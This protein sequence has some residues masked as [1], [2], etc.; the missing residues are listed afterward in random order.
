MDAAYNACIIRN[1]RFETWVNASRSLLQSN[2]FEDK[3][4]SV[5]DIRQL[6]SSLIHT[7]SRSKVPI[8]NG[9]Y[10]GFG[11]DNLRRRQAKCHNP[12]LRHCSQAK[13]SF[14]VN[15]QHWSCLSLQLIPS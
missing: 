9:I 3:D 5:L 2:H 1:E 12:V 4:A 14:S 13:V 15:F 10:S 8:A 7:I 6:H 11:E